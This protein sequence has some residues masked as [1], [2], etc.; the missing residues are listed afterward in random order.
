MSEDFSLESEGSLPGF[1]NNMK[2]LR[3]GMGLTQEE[4]ANRIGCSRSMYQKV[5]LGIR[6][7]SAE[8]NGKVEDAFQA[9]MRDICPRFYIGHKY[10]PP[11][12]E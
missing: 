5:E 12:G 10:Y 11:K 3:I 8:Y 9:N 2:R 1:R 4:I 7:F 6:V